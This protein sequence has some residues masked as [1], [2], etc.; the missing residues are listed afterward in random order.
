MRTVGDVTRLLEKYPDDL[1]IMVRPDDGGDFYWPICLINMGKACEDGY[2]VYDETD[3]SAQDVLVL[4][5]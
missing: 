1:P 3:E 2:I 5:L 4:V